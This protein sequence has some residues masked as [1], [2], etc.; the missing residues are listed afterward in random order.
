MGTVSPLSFCVVGLGLHA[1]KRIIPALIQNNQRNIAV[2]SSSVI[3]EESIDFSYVFNSLN[4]S[5]NFLST[6][7]IYILCS[8]PTFHFHQT[9]SILEA[10]RSVFIEKPAFLSSKDARI[11]IDLC[12]KKDL[13]LVELFMYK[14]TN[15]YKEFISFWNCNKLQIK[16]ISMTF[17]VPQFSPSTFRD[18]LP[19][20]E[21]ILFDIGC[22]PISLLVEIIPNTI[23]LNFFNIF[24]ETN[25]SNSRL[26]K[27]STITEGINIFISIGITENY[28]N[29]ISIDLLGGLNIVYSPFF[30]GVSTNKLINYKYESGSREE[31]LKDNNGFETMFNISKN[32]WRKT[33]NLR[34]SK[35][36]EAT[37]ILEKL[38]KQLLDSDA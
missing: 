29:Y 31:I 38:N 30:H 23:N 22:Y 6:D 2:V 28:Q 25:T 18:K 10:G 21:T 32:E 16:N 11:A 35:I 4:N 20:L 36:I 24:V 14:Y 34:F 15:L 27:I 26:I 3:D 9:I 33:Q 12:K 37:S 17:T 19:L 13:I 5:F 1:K 8:P 7:V